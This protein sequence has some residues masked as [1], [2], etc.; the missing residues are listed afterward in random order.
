MSFPREVLRWL[1]SLDLSHSFHN[2]KRDFANGVL[3]AEILSRYF[4]G[5]LQVNLLYTGD[6]RERREDNWQQLSKFFQRKG[7]QVPQEA[8]HAVLNCHQEAAIMFLCNVYSMLTG[9]SIPEQ[10]KAIPNP[11]ESIPSYTLPTTA[12]IIKSVGGVQVKNEA[13]LQAH[14]DYIRALR[15]ASASNHQQLQTTP[16]DSVEFSQPALLSSQ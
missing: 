2:P 16:V 15:Q 3:I 5:E 9:R 7:I 12:T 14:K 6:S 10:A 13:V 4:V 1:Q 8:M 11:Y